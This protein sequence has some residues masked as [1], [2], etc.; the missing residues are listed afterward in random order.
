[1]EMPPVYI[2]GLH[3]A[4]GSKRISAKELGARFSLT[5]EQVTQKTGVT[6]LYRFS[7]NETLVS[8]STQVTKKLLDKHLPNGRK[9]KGIIASSNTTIETLLPGYATTVGAALGFKNIIADQ[10]GMGCGGGMQALRVAYDRL[11]VEAMEGKPSSYFLVLAGDATAM[12]LDPS[13]ITTALL[14]SEGVSA[15]LLTN[16]PECSSNCYQIKAIGTKSV[17]GENLQLMSTGNPFWPDKRGQLNCFTMKGSGVFRFGVKLVP[18]FLELVGVKKFEDHW[19]LFPHQPNLRMLVA[20][21][22][23]AGLLPEQVYTD[24]IQRIGNCSTAAVFLG[25]EDGLN[26][27]LFNFSNT[28][29]IGAFGAELTVGAALLE[30]QGDPSRIL[31]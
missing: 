20:M 3:G 9:I 18:E 8:V 30:P 10:V 13:D 5:S 26:R 7:E 28:V 14:F 17:L 4:V 27:R 12:T 19:M 16:D 6:N 2:V 21:T 29:L 1:M 15:L 22:E 31:C 11:V 25:L 24:G 23:N